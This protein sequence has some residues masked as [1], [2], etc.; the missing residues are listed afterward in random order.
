M[1][2]MTSRANKTKAGAKP[3]SEM[4]MP[5]DKPKSKEKMKKRKA[6]R[7]LSQRSKAS[8]VRTTMPM[9]GAYTSA[10]TAC[11]QNVS[12]KANSRAFSAATLLRQSIERASGR[13]CTITRYRPPMPSAPIRLARKVF[14]HAAAY[15]VEE[16]APEKRPALGHAE[17]LQ[18]KELSYNNL[19]DLD[20]ALE[21]AL[22][23]SGP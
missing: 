21:C 4:C 16:G 12:E 22:E 9:L 11:D 18:G 19:L 6:R 17:V 15:D 2:K 1:S 8:R 23:F 5:R 10:I 13:S 7:V 14:A 20:A 3:R